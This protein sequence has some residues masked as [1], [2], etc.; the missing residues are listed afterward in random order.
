MRG[1]IGLFSTQINIFDW[2][3]PAYIFR[4]HKHRVYDIGEHVGYLPYCF[5]VN[6]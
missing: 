1:G 2:K 4:G 3:T 5:F 6:I